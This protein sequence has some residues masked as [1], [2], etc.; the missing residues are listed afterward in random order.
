MKNLRLITSLCICV[1]A[2]AT[3]V[4]NV[5][6]CRRMGS[7]AEPDPLP[8]IERTRARIAERMSDPAYTN[9]LAVLADKQAELSRLRSE[10][11]HEF[12]SWCGVFVA[13]N[14]QA[15]AIF[16]QIQALMG[17]GMSRTNA[18]F[19]AKA[20]EFEALV[21]ADPQGRQ[22]LDKRDMIAEALAEHGRVVRAFIGARVRRVASEHAGEERAAAERYR[23]KLIKEG[24]IKPPAPRPAPTNLPPP[25]T[26]GWWT[27]QPPASSSVPSS[28]FKVQS[29]GGTPQPKTK[30]QEPRTKN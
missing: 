30:N 29:S 18:T 6:S 3:I 22:L 16:D 21:A 28:Q 2:L 13:S 17:E 20:A 19:A 7:P 27:N 12:E 9:G 10:A 24:K 8:A 15:R 1:G 14:A 4:V 5:I 26:E 23:E 25:R 11:A